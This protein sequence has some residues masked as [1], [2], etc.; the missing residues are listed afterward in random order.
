MFWARS[1]ET[2]PDDA[3]ADIT[4]GESADDQDASELKEIVLAPPLQGR[5]LLPAPA[6][7]VISGIT[8]LTSFYV[9]AGTKVGGW[10]L[11]AGR[12]AT[13]KTLSVS[14]SALES[15][16]V[17]AGR[18][19]SARSHGDLG[20]SEA[21]NLL[22]RSISALHSTI[23]TVSFVASAGFYLTEASMNSISGLSIQG[24]ATLN[25]ILGSTES[26]R[27][28]AAIITLIKD[29][30]NKPEPGS[31]GEVVTYLDL[32]IGTIGFV[33]LQRWGRRKTELDFRDAGGEETIWDAV[34]DDKGFKADVVGTR[35]K[36]VI[37]IQPNPTAPPMTFASPDGEDEFD[38]LERGTLF[39]PSAV[40]S[41]PETQ[42]NLTD[43]EIRERIMSQ[44]PTGTRA[45]ITEETI[46]AKT[47]KVDIYD[48]QTTHID[49]P[50]GT[51]MVAESLH[52]GDA[53][54]GGQNEPHQTVIFRTALKKS[55]SRDIPSMVDQLR[56][57]RGDESPVDHHDGDGL[58]MKNAGSKRISVVDEPAPMEDAAVFN[59]DHEEEPVETTAPKDVGPVANQKKSRRP[60]F[61]YSKS[62]PDTEATS[63]IP[64]VKN[65]REKPVSTGQDDKDGVI[66]KALKTLSPSHS[67]AGV[68]DIHKN[69][70]HQRKLP[71]P[72]PAQQPF[73]TRV[74]STVR[75]DMSP[76]KNFTSLSHGATPMT[77]PSLLRGLSQDQSSS[78][79]ALHHRRRDSA[80]SQ[81]TETYSAHSVESRPGSPTFTR[82]HTRVVSGVTQSKS[83][84]GLTLDESE[85]RIDT[86]SGTVHRRRSRSFVPSLYSMATKDSQEA[87]ILAPKT[88]VHRKSIY[89]DHNILNDL[90]SKGKVPG[91]FPD[92]HMVKTVR[93]FARF[94]SA[95]YGSNFLRV[96]GLSSAEA[97]LSKAT[98]LM[99]LD[100]HH[101]H[102]SFSSHTGL[103]PDTIL[104]SSF[105]DPKGVTG[106]TDWSPSAISPLIHFITIDD[107]SKAVVLTCR[108][109]L[110]FEDVLTDM[111]C[112]YD[113]LVWQGQRYKVHKGVHA[114]ARRLLGGS[115]SRVMATIKATLEQYPD[116]G[117]VLC[118]HSLGGAV[119]AIL[120][121]L[122][123]E[124]SF[125]GD[126]KTRFVTAGNMP[127]LITTHNKTT[128]GAGPYT[129]SYVPPITL[130]AGRPI[131]VYAYGT[132]ACMSELLRVATRGLITTVVNHSDIVP[133]LSLGILH[134]FR[135][136]ALHLKTDTT[137]ALG[138]LKTRVWQRV[139]NAVKSSFYNNY[140]KGPPPPENMAG[141]GLGEDTW[142]WAAL[143]TLRAAMINDKL[144]P[145]GEVFVVET[146]RVFDRLDPDVAREAVFGPDD[147]KDDRTEKLYR[148]LGRPATRVQFKLIRDV[149]TRF[150]ELRFGRDMFGDHS[151]GRY[152]AALAALE[153]GICED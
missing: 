59:S 85:S 19:V 142:A 103:P 16:L 61:S 83:E 137:D 3:T 18:D 113:D 147:S 33:M 139:K 111:T 48:S 149:E 151:P 22:E 58:Y 104:L 86:A 14:R 53:G 129:S 8:G 134:D 119:A 44:L 153:K 23:S 65:K 26:S 120:A 123:S 110:G 141:D 20:R 74:P 50:P 75:G 117:L 7:A 25:A 99:T 80:V 64:R 79:F 94:A 90:I 98:E 150:G 148:A 131:H 27:A 152:E 12:E 97:Q 89:E 52:H 39:D 127:K 136:V 21:E 2:G 43:E 37:S 36:G 15:V 49:P 124:P 70:P 47:I 11:Y 115:G 138:A 91:I 109:T 76:R 81:T 130:P 68:K 101:E 13:L 41:V 125:D 96:M 135:T 114:S 34:I 46:T 78:Y 132:P 63:W 140:S 87:I 32:I 29:E 92:R 5:T 112:D 116:Y 42:T 54:N 133:C 62:P 55:S 71:I 108:G 128:G 122:I 67:S 28:V 84:I 88:H 10:G 105:Y 144:V 106:N 60:I 95:S 35:R 77:S 146:T 100:V 51:V 118:G 93:R 17:A 4:A 66:K 40:T 57:T 107:D 72:A 9:R 73:S 30:L 145:P 38:V 126:G 121:I 31:N 24:L 6:A 143:K 69:P 82:T 102:S 56:L 1:K 45:V